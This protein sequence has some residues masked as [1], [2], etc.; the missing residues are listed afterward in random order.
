MKFKTVN[1]LD[2]RLLNRKEYTIAVEDVKQTPKRVDLLKQISAK[3]GLDDK[4]VVIHKINTTF[5]KPEVKVF[6]KVYD[7]KKDLDLIENKKN[8]ETLKKLSAPP[9]VEK[10]EEAPVEAP[11]EE[12]PAEEKKESE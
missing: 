2:N 5:G 3:M 4:K 1:E 10:K 9:K 6:V 7:S 11:K 12:A 8:K